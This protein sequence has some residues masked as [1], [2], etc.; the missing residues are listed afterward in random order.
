MSHQLR[1]GILGGTFDPIHLGHVAAAEAAG[2]ALA[3]D[4]ILVV[5]SHDPPHRRPGPRASGYHRFAMVALAIAETP[6]LAASDLELRAEGLSYTSAT[7]RRLVAQGLAPTQLFF[8]TGADAFAEIATWSEYPSILDLTH[9]VVIS[10]PGTAVDSMPVLLPDLAGRMEAV[11]LEDT[12][13]P[14][15]TAPR[16]ARGTRVFLVEALT[17]DV[18]STEVRRLAGAHHPL[19]G[20]VAPAVERYMRRHRLY[21]SET[22]CDGER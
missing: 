3:L 22:T 20:L 9:F 8:I 5:A 7:L 10:R 17:P 19:E 4:E 13:T 12:G 11:A 14:D 21:V 15:R 2:R 18:S 6:R 16:N 1:L